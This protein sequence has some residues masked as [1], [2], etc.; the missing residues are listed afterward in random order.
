MKNYLKFLKKLPK[1]LRD[2]IIKAIFDIGNNNLNKLD[3]KI[4]K[5]HA[6]IYRCRTG[7]IRII[8]EKRNNTNI[9]HDIGYR[10]DIYK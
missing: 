1:Q 9:I 10:G 3:I 2:N 7:K 6:N 8:F 5:G 4:L